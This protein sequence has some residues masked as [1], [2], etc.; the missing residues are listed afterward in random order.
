M[1]KAMCNWT[2]YDGINSLPVG[3]Y[4]WRVSHQ[5]LD[6]V[7]VQFRDKVRLRGHGHGDRVAS[8]KFD[9]WDGYRVHLPDGLQ[10]RSVDRNDPAVT[11]EGIDLLT[12]PFCGEPVM[13]AFHAG[14]I[15]AAPHQRGSFE[16]KHCFADVQRD[17]PRKAAELWNTRT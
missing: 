5:H 3:E 11:V 13:W 14:F 2:D 17:D 10:Y 9:Y 6:S 4:L 16:I 12:C 15:G 8:P 1:D 7:V